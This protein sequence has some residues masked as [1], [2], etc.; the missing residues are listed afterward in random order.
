MPLKK[1]TK[2]VVGS[3]PNRRRRE[4]IQAES[5]RPNSESPSSQRDWKPKFPESTPQQRKQ[6]LASKRPMLV[7]HLPSHVE[8]ARDV[9]E[10]AGFRPVGN[11]TEIENFA[12]IE[13]LPPP[14]PGKL[15]TAGVADLAS[16]VLRSAGYDVGPEHI[17]MKE[18]AG[19]LLAL[20][21]L[22]LAPK[23]TYAPKTK[24]LSFRPLPGGG[25]RAETQFSNDALLD[26]RDELVRCL[27]DVRV[28]VR[29]DETISASALA[30]RFSGTVLASA[31]EPWNWD[32]WRKGF[33][34]DLTS[35]N[36]ALILLRDTTGIKT[37]SLE[38]RLSQ[39][40]TGR[41]A[42]HR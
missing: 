25:V 7:G 32:E 28:L 14:H 17:S 26:T 13:C 40:R 36:A 22:R 24:M 39:T 10:R 8:M 38:T 3:K 42:T 20:I 27:E 37:S 11:V 31:A 6:A 29:K 5:L 41:R 23:M 2:K 30:D 15:G 4:S 19:R 35:K 16:Q 21:P 12:W 18:V 34:K 9:L 1:S 33:L